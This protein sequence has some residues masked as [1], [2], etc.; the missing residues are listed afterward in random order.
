MGPKGNTANGGLPKKKGGIA[1]KERGVK[2][3]V[4]GEE[5]GDGA[6][7][8]FK[9]AEGLMMIYFKSKDTHGGLFLCQ[10]F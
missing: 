1:A 7:H 9:T 4:R 8:H 5:E 6:E 2:G 10:P 3:I